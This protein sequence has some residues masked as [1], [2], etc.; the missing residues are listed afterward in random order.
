MNDLSLYWLMLCIV[1]S[2][3]SYNLLMQEKK[4][5]GYNKQLMFKVHVS[6]IKAILWF[7]VYVFAFPILLLKRCCVWMKMI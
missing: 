7:F 6:G 2:I 5:Y 1:A 3:L 4:K